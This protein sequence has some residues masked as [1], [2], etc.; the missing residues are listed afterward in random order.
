MTPA[1][2]SVGISFP[3]PE[4]MDVPNVAFSSLNLVAPMAAYGTTGGNS[5]EFTYM[6]GG[7]SLTVQRITKAVGAQGAILPVI[8][9]AMNSTW[10]LEFNGPSLHCNPVDSVL[11]DAVLAN[12]LA[13]TFARNEDLAGNCT[14]GPGYVAWHPEFMSPDDSTDEYLPFLL[15]LVNPTRNVSKSSSCVMNSYSNALNNDNRRGYPH[16][17]SLSLSCHCAY[18]L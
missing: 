3:P 11:R 18:P 7:P 12:V 2:L 5:P 15:D 16:R 8:A 9:P 6:Y 13:Y 17:H 10:D 4:Y 14:T 1:T